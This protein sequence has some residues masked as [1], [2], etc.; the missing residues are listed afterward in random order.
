MTPPGEPAGLGE[1]V[2]RKRREMKVRGGPVSAS[3]GL[4]PFVPTVSPRFAPPRHLQAFAEIIERATREPVRACISVPPRHGKT[5]LVLHAIP[6]IL[7]RH[8]D[9]PIGYVSYAADFATSKS[10]SARDYAR[11]AGVPLRDDANALHEWRTPLGGG[12]LATGIGGPLTGHGLR[13]L[14]V[15]DPTKN[16]V[17]AESFTIR[18]RNHQWFTSTAMTRLEPDGSAIVVHTRW[19]EDDLI[20]RLKKETELWH[21]TGGEEGERWEMLNLQAIDDVTGEALWPERWPVEVLEKRKR[22]VG[23]YDWASLFQ[24]DPRPREGKLFRD[25]ARYDEPSVDGR[26]I[27]IGVDV[28]ATA[29]TRANWSVATVMAFEGYDDDL[30]AD[31]LEVLRMQEEIPEVCRRLEGL[32]ERWA[33]PLVVEDAGVGKAVPQTMLDVNP[34]LDIIRIQPKGDKFTRAQSYAAAWN[35]GRVRLPKS[36]PWLNPFMQ[37]HKDFTGKGDACDDDVDSGA[38]AWNYA[39]AQKEPDYGVIKAGRR[40]W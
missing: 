23:P 9:F 31:V 16:R 10:R 33:A 40:R 37:V 17:E 32:Q 11:L 15:D 4:V 18:E 12:V 21:E 38:H 19:H 2:L 28:A 34:R 29:S 1:L 26:R 35:G 20:G 13:I 36:A 22:I 8:P 5:E 3:L 24:G 39:R 30:E 14:F 7:K 27:V 25:P 6:W